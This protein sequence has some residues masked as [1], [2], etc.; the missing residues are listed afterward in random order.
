MTTPTGAGWDN[1][2]FNYYNSATGAPIAGGNLYLLDQ[3]YGGTPQTLST[4]TTGFLAVAA[5]N[6]GGTAWVFD[7]SVTLSGNTQYFFYPDSRFNGAGGTTTTGDTYAGGVMYNSANGTG[8]YGPSSFADVAFNLSGASAAP[9][10]IPGTGL[11]SLAGLLI[12]GLGLRFR[13]CLA[14]AKKARQRVN[15]WF[16]GLLHTSK[17]A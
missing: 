12:G 14:A 9:G 5:P 17:P 6:G 8:N 15:A 2:T 7:P 1:I 10:P 3:A 13:L 11:L 4:S 16:A